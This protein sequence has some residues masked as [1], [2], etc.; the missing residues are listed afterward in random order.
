MLETIA[1][2]VETQSVIG[3]GLGSVRIVVAAE[4]DGRCGFGFDC[5]GVVI[6]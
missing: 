4:L 6:R 2:D 1:Y 3:R 5:A